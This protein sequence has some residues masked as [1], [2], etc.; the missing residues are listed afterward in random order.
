M[1]FFSSFSSVEEGNPFSGRNGG[2]E[3]CGAFCC[4]WPIAAVNGLTE[5]GGGPPPP[6]IGGRTEI[7]AK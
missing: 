2:P 3:D 1:T 6:I 7:R 5:F 4:C